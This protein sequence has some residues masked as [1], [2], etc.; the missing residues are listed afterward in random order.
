MEIIKDFGV[1]PLL[2]SAQIVNFLIILFILRK[3]AFK[4]LLDI[5]KK[6][7]SEIKEG[8]K[9]ADEGRKILEEAKEKEKNILSKALKDAES[10]ILDSKVQA[11][12]EA[13]KIL[14]S[15]RKEA[16]D[17]KNS[18]IAQMN[19]EYKNAE[20]KLSLSLGNAAINL[21][22]KSMKDVFGNAKQEELLKMAIK[23]INKLN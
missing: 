19:E 18:T 5:L 17:I 13:E 21:L 2:L 7:Q 16:E 12:E 15:A 6:R 11:K 14:E 9:S 22:E 1:D 3:F 10:L 8:L 4:P 23:K 20:K